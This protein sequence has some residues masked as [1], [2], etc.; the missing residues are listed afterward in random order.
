MKPLEVVAME[1]AAKMVSHWIANYGL[2][3]ARRMVLEIT[4]GIHGDLGPEFR[5]A[6][7]TAFR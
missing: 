1:L 3:D 6:Y 4:S 2:K 7:L 5:A